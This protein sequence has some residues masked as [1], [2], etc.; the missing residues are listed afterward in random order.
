MQV[1]HP[2]EHGVLPEGHR[3]ILASQGRSYAA[4]SIALCANGHFR[5]GLDMMYSHGGF[6]F[7]I[8]VD[9]DGFP[10]LAAARTAAIERMLRQWHTPFP[11]EPESVRVELR[12]LRQQVESHLLQPSLF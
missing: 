2:N 11:S 9:S 6:C 4:I 10:T 5:Y 3:E 7:P 8:C 12:E 1:N